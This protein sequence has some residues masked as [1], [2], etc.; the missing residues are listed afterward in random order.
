M[1][2]LL[3]LVSWP[4]VFYKGRKEKVNQWKSA[5]AI[6][7]SARTLEEALVGAD[8][9]VGLS[10]SG[11][12]KP[13]FLKK[14]N[15]D[16]IIFAMA[17]PD[18]EIMPDE[19]KKVSPSA[20]IATGRSDLPNQV[21]N[22]LGFPYIFRGAL[23]VRSKVINEEMKT[24]AALAIAKLAREDVPDEVVAAMGGDRP[25]Y[26]KDYI[27]PSTFDPRLITVIPA[28][29]AKAAM[30]SG[31]AR[32]NIDNF[33]FYKEQLKQR[34]DPTVTIMQGINSYIKKNQKKKFIIIV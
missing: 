5:H 10:V 9:F 27:I 17:N 32:K 24:A 12:L 23:D 29:V 15:S 31:V 19:A 25:H 3:D 22:V 28:A 4:N 34:L 11:I 26:G 6:D 13:S 20:I 2:L 1:Y 16:P 30:D 18:P 21:N 33:E 8:V 7:T 14:M